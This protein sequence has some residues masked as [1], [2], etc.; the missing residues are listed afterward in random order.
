MS[1]LSVDTIQ[2]KT[3]AGTV[4]MP[5]GVM[6]QIQQTHLTAYTTTSSTS[7]VD[8]GLAVSITPKFTS[9]KVLISGHLNACYSNGTGLYAVYILYKNDLSLEPIHNLVGFLN[10]GE[11]IGYNTDWSFSFLDTPNTTSA[12]TYK[13]KFNTSGGN[14]YINNYGVA[15]NNT[16][17]TI[18]AMEIA[19]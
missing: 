15:N 19:A 17:S 2:G 7:Q 5:A 9:S 4:A 14:S 10:G 16:R 6:L 3:T 8:T 13:L 1:T 11:E 12:L 18:T